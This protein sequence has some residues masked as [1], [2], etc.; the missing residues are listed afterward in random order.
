MINCPE[1]GFKGEER[2]QSALVWIAERPVR[3][4]IQAGA[5]KCPE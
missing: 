1:S 4:A 2:G 3:S 5:E